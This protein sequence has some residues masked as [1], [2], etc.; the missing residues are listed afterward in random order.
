ME[1]NVIILSALSTGKN[2]RIT[3]EGAV[4]G[5]GGAGVWGQLHAMTNK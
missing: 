1:G 3:K 2:L 4:E 5:L